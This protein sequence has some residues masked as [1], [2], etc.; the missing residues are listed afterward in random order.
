MSGQKVQI[1]CPACRAVLSIKKPDNLNRYVTCSICKQK[2]PLTKFAFVNSEDVKK[3]VSDSVDSNHHNDNQD[4]NHNGVNIN[5][6]SSPENYFPHLRPDNP[7]HDAGGGRPIS[8]QIPGFHDR[9]SQNVNTQDTIYDPDTIIYDKFNSTVGR[10]VQKDSANVY[11]LL[12][13]KNIIGRSA[14][15]SKATIPIITGPSKQMSREHIII[16]VKNEPHKG[17][18][19]YLSLYKEKVNYTTRNGKQILYGDRLELKH[20]DVISLPGVTLSFEI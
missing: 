11:Q 16:E 12:H 5:N 6:P 2:S 9:S 7:S 18:V 15:A 19:H 14:S 3:N 13:G 10:L 20:G 17:L 1:K 4:N 8:P